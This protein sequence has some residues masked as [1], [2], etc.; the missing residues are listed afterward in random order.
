MKK[1]TRRKFIK[2][3]VLATLGIILLDAFWFEKYMI[4]W[5]YFDMS[6]NEENKIKIIQI[7]DLHFDGL[8]SLHKSIAKKINTI[9]PDLIFITGDSVDKNEYVNPLNDFLKLIDPS[10]KKYAITGNWEYWGHIDLKQLK[11]VYEQNNC[12]LLINEN[13]R[14][15]VNNRE[16]NII[17]IDDY[18][19]GHA[20]FL[21]AI[22]NLQPADTNIVLSHCPEH[23]DIITAQKGGLD[24]DVVLSGHTHGGQITLF[25]FA[26]FTPQGSGNYIKGWYKDSEPKMYISK[27]IGTSI[28]PIRFGARAEMVVM[29]V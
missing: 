21:E 12:E 17:G 18:V 5:N 25:G 27:G 3:G 29:E 20:D 16:L 9:Q 11:S 28:L 4:D 2:R 8:K 6:N 1:L 15:S 23:R 13:K 10:I 22:K 24:I 19:G 26:P 7:S 14:F